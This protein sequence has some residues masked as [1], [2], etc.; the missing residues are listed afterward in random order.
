ML[1]YPLTLALL[2]CAPLVV[3]AAEP[4]KYDYR[5]LA[6]T[7]TSTM[8]KEMNA[9]A[10]DGYVFQAVM[11][12]ETAFGGKEVVAVMAKQNGAPAVAPR[13]YMLI[14]TSRT[15]TMQ[16][17]L[18][19]AGDEGFIYRGQTVFESTFGGREVAI[20]LELDPTA[21][22][23]RTEYKLLATSRTSTMQKELR[24]AGDAGFLLVGMT[25]GKTAM[26]GDE[27]V[28]ILKRTAQ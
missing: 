15:S 2:L 10:S 19:R 5:V 8:Q 11:G 3:A 13:K 22:A 17:E 26:G 14:A 21:P 18:Q 20:I 27:L 25:V 1:K 4:V 16:K 28:S 12:G 23:P 6:T 9:A 24:E 7:K